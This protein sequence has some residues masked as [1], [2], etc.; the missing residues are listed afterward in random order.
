M[1]VT[2]EEA[3][4]Y[5]YQNATLKSLKILPLEQALGY[6]LA[7]EVRASHNLPPFDNSA[8]DGYAVKVE[9]AGREVTV[10]HT[11]FAGD[12]SNEELKGGFAIKI[13][14]GAKIP[15]GC[16]AI[17]P[18]E[19]VTALD[20][21]VKLPDNLKRGKHIRLC[22]E[23]IKSGATLLNRGQKIYAHHITLLA[24]Q[25]RSHIKVYKKPKVAIF[26]SGN[27]LKMHYES[28]ESYQLYNTN[29]PT[30]FARAQELGCDVDFIGTAGDSLEEIHE[31]I[32][33]ALNSD[34]IITSGGVSVG[35]ADFTKEAF[36]AF[37]CDVFF[38]HVEIKPGKPTTFGRI[39]DTLVLNLP[40]NPLAA[41]LNFEL[42]AQS[43]IL[44]LSGD[45]AKYIAPIET[46]MANNY[47]IKGG[48]RTLI[49][50]FFDGASF[51]P[52]ENF[53]PGM[54]SPLAVSN[55]YIIVDENCELLKKDGSVKIISTRFSFNSK[56]KSDLIT[57]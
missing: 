23:D 16:E 44:A 21:G 34:L 14:T 26:A 41:A 54:I 5:I 17:V 11:I 51:A 32:K 27:E 10:N 38:D 28:V 31:H 6:I 49:P 24:S 9:D 4:K 15:L 30:F 53:S 57:R 33:S 25:G 55:S 12:N 46:K 8:M 13:M 39:K 48:R 3:L 56:E 47:V 42:F 36:G 52:Y 18:I 50:G 1:A 7:E 43:I 19:E 20:N 22:G 35:D 40:G 29:T 45:E 37:G 2:I